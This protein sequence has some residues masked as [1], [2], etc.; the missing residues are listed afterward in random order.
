[1]KMA[2]KM[3]NH[4]FRL[5][6][7]HCILVHYLRNYSRLIVLHNRKREKNVMKRDKSVSI[8]YIVWLYYVKN[9]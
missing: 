8:K 3:S 2:L 5:K 6:V 9:E 7:F 4:S 1:M